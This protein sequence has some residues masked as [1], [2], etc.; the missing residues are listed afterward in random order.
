M[1]SISFYHHFSTIEQNLS[2]CVEFVR[3]LAG[4]QNY[5]AYSFGPSSESPKRAARIRTIHSTDLIITHLLHFATFIRRSLSSCILKI[6]TAIN[7]QKILRHPAS[8]NFSYHVY[9]H[10][11]IYNL[12]NIPCCKSRG[13]LQVGVQIL[14]VYS[15]GDQPAPAV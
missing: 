4:L 11:F 9:F 10:I 12:S 13:A 1:I 14:A 2:N 15:F 6:Q 3:C 7:H 8:S 5:F